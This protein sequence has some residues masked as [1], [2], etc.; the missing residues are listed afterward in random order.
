MRGGPS[1]SPGLTRDHAPALTLL[2]TQGGVRERGGQTGS[3]A[4]SAEVSL[5]NEPAPGSE[6]ERTGQ[7]G[8]RR[9]LSDSRS[10]AGS[11]RCSHFPSVNSVLFFF[12][13]TRTLVPIVLKNIGNT[14]EVQRRIPPILILLQF[15]SSHFYPH[16][17]FTSLR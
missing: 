6:G 16:I 2:L 11:F 15:L 12:L 7:P 4:R 14:E 8:P 9:H 1:R 3:P 13:N 17:P 10:V 5:K